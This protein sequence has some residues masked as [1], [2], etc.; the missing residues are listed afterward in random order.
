[1]STLL[2]KVYGAVAATNCAAAMA[3]ITEGWSWQDIEARFGHIDDFIEF[4]TEERVWDPGWGPAWHSRAYA[5]R[6]GMTED[7][8]EG[9]RLCATAVIEK[10]GRIDVWDLARVWVRDIQPDKFGY[11]LGGQDQTIYYLLKA[12][13]PPTETGRYAPQPGSSDTGK[14]ML[15]IGIVNAGDPRQAALDVYDVGR[16]R[17][18]AHHAFNFG[19]ECAAANQAGVAEALRPTASKESVMATMLSCLSETSRR[20]VLWALDMAGRYPDPLDLR[21]VFHEKYAG[22][23]PSNAVEVLAEACALLQVCNWDPARICI[24]A[25]NLG[26]GGASAGVYANG[27]AGALMGVGAL[28]SEWIETV[29]KATAED[30]HTVSRRSL[31]ETAEG[32]YRALQNEIA[33]TKRWMGEVEQQMR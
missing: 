29:D 8:I 12:G 15:P 17:D 27:L 3:V 30:P 18:V 2:E 10:G 11:H 7:G 16:Y 5:H 26:R 33:K 23:P 22:R 19:L 14:T 31:R 24:A 1:M 20:E 4:E 6:R 9:Q 25:A 28:P 32:L 13:M 21:K